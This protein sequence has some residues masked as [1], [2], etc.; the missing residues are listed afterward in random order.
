MAYGRP[1]ETMKI[2]VVGS[3]GY[4]CRQTL[5]ELGP[6]SRGYVRSVL[7][8]NFR[9]FF[10]RCVVPYG[11]KG[12]PAGVVGS[13]GCACRDVL[14]EVAALEGISIGCFLASPMDGLITYHLD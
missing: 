7:E 6:E 1:G 12:C 3:V 11:Q 13:F 4:A 2:G 5:M 10:R 9:L 8:E 14:E